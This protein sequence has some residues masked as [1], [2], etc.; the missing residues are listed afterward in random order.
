[1]GRII[2]IICGVACIPC[3][4]STCTA[5]YSTFLRMC[6]YEL[7]QRGTVGIV[8]FEPKLTIIVIMFLSD[9]MIVG[10]DSLT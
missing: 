5:F 10:E 7:L 9:C 3:V 8:W 2:S 4:C 6:A 1:M